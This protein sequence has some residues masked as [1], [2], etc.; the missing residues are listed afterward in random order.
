V[1]LPIIQNRV[2]HAS[3]IPTVT[4]HGSHVVI[5]RTEAPQY[6]SIRRSGLCFLKNG[7]DLY[8]QR[9]GCL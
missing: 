8:L 6:V 5:Y 9:F 2:S 1:L 3:K 7:V 4:N